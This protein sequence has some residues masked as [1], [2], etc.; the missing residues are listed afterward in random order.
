MHSKI[1]GIKQ[2]TAVNIGKYEVAYTDSSLVGRKRFV[3]S[4]MDEELKL[5]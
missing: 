2:D 3:N 4:V 5:Y 1:T